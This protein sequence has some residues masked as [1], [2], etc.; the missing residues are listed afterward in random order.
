MEFSEKIRTLRINRGLSQEKLAEQFDVSRQTISKW[1]AGTT[2]PEV[3]KLIALSDFFQVTI[4]YLLR[5]KQVESEMNGE[6]DRMVIRFLN[7]SYEMSDISRQLVGIMEDGV[8]DSE[9]VHEMEQIVCELDNISAMIKR[10]R[11][12]LYANRSQE[13]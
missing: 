5:D 7:S 8:I 3:D 13:E 1:E 9:E 11:E 12:V 2:L 4:D 6:L 10:M